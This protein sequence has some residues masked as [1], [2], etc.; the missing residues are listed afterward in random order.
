M[1]VV[2]GIG[3]AEAEAAPGANDAVLAYRNAARGVRG[4][5]AP[6]YELVTAYVLPMDVSAVTRGGS[7]IHVVEP[8]LVYEVT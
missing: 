8:A 2:S 7:D 4:V 3:S 1:S 6:K 5:C